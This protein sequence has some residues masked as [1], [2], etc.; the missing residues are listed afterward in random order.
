[1]AEEKSIIQEYLDNIEDRKKKESK[2]LIHMSIK[3][4]EALPYKG[5]D[6]ESFI[7]ELYNKAD[8][9]N[10]KEEIESILSGTY[11]FVS[12]RTIT[13]IEDMLDIELI[14]FV[15]DK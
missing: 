2:M 10:T 12:I 1:M 11:S 7:D 8:W 9:L 4:N 5:Y 6:R 14:K 13:L 15:D 3:V